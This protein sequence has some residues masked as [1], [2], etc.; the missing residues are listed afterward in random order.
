[1]KTKSSQITQQ[2]TFL[3]PDISGVLYKL[4]FPKKLI[5]II[6]NLLHKKK[7]HKKQK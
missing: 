3:K 5:S 4:K 7:I 6:I 1:L 2:I